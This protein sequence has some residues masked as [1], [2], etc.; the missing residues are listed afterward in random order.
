M[1]IR[2][3]TRIPSIMYTLY[4]WRS[5]SA[6]ISW[7]RILKCDIFYEITFFHWFDYGWWQLF[8]FFPLSHHLS[9]SLY[10]PHFTYYISYSPPDGSK[11]LSYRNIGSPHHQAETFSP[12]TVRK[13]SIIRINSRPFWEFILPDSSRVE[14]GAFAVISRLSFN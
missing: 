10:H 7:C 9:P 6:T 4:K 12:Y 5:F 14:R 2:R 3:P 1:G 8:F 13:N 11:A